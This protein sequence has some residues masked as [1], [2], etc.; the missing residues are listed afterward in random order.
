MS[1]DTVLGVFP[2]AEQS[3]RRNRLLAYGMIGQYILES[4]DGTL[5]TYRDMMHYWFQANGCNVV[6]SKG[7]TAL[8]DDWYDLVRPSWDGGV[9]FYQPETS[10]ASSGTKVGDNYG[11]TCAPS[12]NSTAGTDGYSGN[13]LFI[14]TDVNWVIDATTH[15]PII[16]AIDGI[17]SGFKRYDPNTFVGVVQMTGYVAQVEDSDTYTIWYSANKEAHAG[18]K[19]LSEAVRW[20]DNTVRPWVIHA[21]YA[22][23]VISNKFTSF[24]GSRVT[25]YDVSH[26][27]SHTYAGN[28]GTGYSGMCYCDA[29]FLQ[30]ML[31][32]KYG[33]LTADGTM[34]Q[35]C[36][37]VNYQYYAKVAETGVKRILV[38]TSE[39]ANFKVG[40]QV[41]VG[42]YGGNLDRNQ[43]AM[44]SISG[45]NGFRVTAVKTVTI[46]STQYSAIYFDADTAF[47]TAANG[48]A[49]TGTTYISSM[50]WCT[51]INDNILGFDGNAAGNT[52]GV[53]PATIQGIEFATGK[54]EV[55]ADTILNLTK[56]GDDYYY[57]PMTC[58]N[59]ANQS[60]SVT[61]NYISTGHKLI[62]PAESA[63]KYITKL[64]WS[65][66]IFFCEKYD[67]TS[68][69]GTKDG[70]Y[71][72]A[73]T[74]GTRESLLFGHL[75]YGVGLGGPSCVNGGHALSH[76]YW[77][78]AGRVS[79]NGSRGELSA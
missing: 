22:A 43:A 21:K 37:Q 55:I 4:L 39:G 75:S 14:P 34:M 77:N 59:S 46:D 49:T 40:M 54:L 41:I 15:E 66:G 45:K 3:E 79:P 50:G 5:A 27:T 74:T 60:T 65:E 73:A 47:D 32:I 7:L 35:G 78:L 11:I 53:Y 17:S 16:T 36:V 24:S 26:N 31:M 6:S 57:E 76:A 33:T 29:S 48:S 9:T 62:Q 20:S 1:I 12:S 18:C 72:L 2:N 69:H 61:A 52:A 8:L 68:S 56:E 44:Y 30:L 71:L 70:I 28:I 51:G 23:Q 64:K 25:S 58:K 13:P 10:T 38:S 19:P 67:G 63:W 42:N